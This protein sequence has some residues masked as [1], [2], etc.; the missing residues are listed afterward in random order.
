MLGAKTRPGFTVRMTIE[1]PWVDVYRYVANPKNLAA[2]AS[3][4]AKGAKVRFVEANR[5]G[6]L[7]HYVSVEGGPEVYVPMR[8]VANGEGAEV[9]LTVFRQPGT[10]EEKFGED[11]QWVRRDL[12][13]LKA[14]LEG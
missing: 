1:K 6:V 7:D 12:E 5:Y 10:S 2:W 14:V 13:A 3:G 11:T 4:L 9:L 8:V